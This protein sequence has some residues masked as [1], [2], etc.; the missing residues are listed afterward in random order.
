MDKEIK[1][2]II[3]ITMASVTNIEIITIIM[4]GKD[5]IRILSYIQLVK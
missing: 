2:E 3:S 1:L 4:R 5:L